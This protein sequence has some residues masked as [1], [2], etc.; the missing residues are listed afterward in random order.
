M[1]TSLSCLFPESLWALGSSI[2]QDVSLGV[3]RQW[4]HSQASLHH[5]QL[6]LLT[7]LKDEK[8]WIK[9]TLK[10]SSLS[11]NHVTNFKGTVK[12]KNIYFKSYLCCYLSIQIAL[13][14]G[15][16]FWRYHLQICLSFLERLMIALALWC[17]KYQKNK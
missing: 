2:M 16:H 9:R 7:V 12:I 8:V 4:W 6:P 10:Y 5:K 14:W 3:G 15:T 13:F 17:S 11:E 1:L